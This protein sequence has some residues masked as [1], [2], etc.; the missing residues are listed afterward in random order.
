MNYNDG[1]PKNEELITKY[2][3]YS[4]RLT[5]PSKSSSYIRTSLSLQNMLDVDN[6]SINTNNDFD[7][8]T[9]IQ[10]DKTFLMPDQ[11]KIKTKSENDIKLRNKS[12]VDLVEIIGGTWAGTTDS[13]ELEKF[14]SLKKNLDK[15]DNIKEKYSSMENGHSNT[16]TK[17]NKSINPLTH[18]LDGNNSLKKNTAKFYTDLEE[19]AKNGS[20][21]S[22]KK[23]DNAKS[24]C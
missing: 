21:N 19:N 18:L 2:G 23:L 17:R 11:K 6:V 16:L 9:V 22:L 10:P 1:K 20:N 13:K 15:N 24:K 3:E 7:Q 12:E 5:T 14:G 4:K 8:N